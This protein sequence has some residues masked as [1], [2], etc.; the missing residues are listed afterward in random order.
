MSTKETLLQQF[1]ACYDEND[2]FVAV[3]NAIEG[4]TPEQAAWKPADTQHSIRELAT[5]LIHDN[6]ACLQR[7]QGIKYT[8][9]AENNDETFDLA[10]GSWEADLKR[11]EAI[12]TKW[13]EVLENADNAKLD[14]LAPHRNET[15]WGMEIANMNAH[16]AYHG[17]QIVLLRKLQGSWNP[18]TGV[19]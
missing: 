5:H 15:N 10:G 16:N 17:G 8:S 1:S 2:W 13:R 19:S 14:E 11:F 12:M 6:N 7:F 3:K 18:E 4:I 9:P